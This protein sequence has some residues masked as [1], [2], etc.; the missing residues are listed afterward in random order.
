MI[1]ESLVSKVA[2]GDD[3]PIQMVSPLV[4]EIPRDDLLNYIS[5]NDPVDLFTARKSNDV[6]MF[7]IEQYKLLQMW[8]MHQDILGKSILILTDIPSV[9]YDAE[10]AEAS[11]RGSKVAYHALIG[12]L[13]EA[14]RRAEM[15]GDATVLDK[16][17]KA[18]TKKSGDVRRMEDT[19]FDQSE[20]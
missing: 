3:L 20:D 9:D 1:I 7:P 2:K 13:A 19:D 11:S 15:V 16:E 17:Q 10:F 5:I 12:D 4:N 14:S 8:N 18:I 6:L